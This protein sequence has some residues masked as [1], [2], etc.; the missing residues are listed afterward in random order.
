VPGLVEP[1]GWSVILV[2]GT[3]FRMSAGPANWIDIRSMQGNTMKKTSSTRV[4][5]TLLGTKAKAI[6]AG[7]LVLGVGTAGTLA[8]WNDSE[9][10]IGNFG[11]GHFELE[12][13]ADGTTFASHE[14]ALGAATLNFQVDADKLSPNATVY[15]PFALKLDS[16]TTHQAEV[17]VETASSTVA[18]TPAS[19][20]ISAFLTYSIT[21]T[22]L[23]DC[24]NAIDNGVSLTTP[25][26]VGGDPIALLSLADT[27]ATYLCIAVTAGEDLPQDLDGSV[28]WKFTAE[29]IDVIA[30]VE[31]PVA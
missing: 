31:Q 29:A 20:D 3:A 7:A 30:V 26:I 19:V 9:F 28:T 16:E 8:T 10:T 25:S 13:S 17:T 15:A 27:N 4:G 24:D 23:G 21:K 18:T 14:S 6:F 22:S 12:G 11:S 2:V 1:C 5:A